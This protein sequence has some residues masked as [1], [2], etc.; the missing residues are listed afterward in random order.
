[1]KR[2]SLLKSLSNNVSGCM[3]TQRVH[4]KPPLQS[5]HW[6]HHISFSRTEKKAVFKSAEGGE[7]QEV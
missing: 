2:G 6:T 1:M 4:D 5:T 7:R 3:V